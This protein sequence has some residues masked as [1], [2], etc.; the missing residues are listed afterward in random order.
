MRSAQDPKSEPQRWSPAIFRDSSRRRS[1]RVVSA[2]GGFIRNWQYDWRKNRIP[3]KQLASSSPLQYMLLDCVEQALR[4]ARL[5]VACLRSQRTAV[6]VGGGFGGEFGAALVTSIRIPEVERTLRRLLAEL[7][8]PSS[9]QQS[10]PAV[11]GQRLLEAFPGIL[12]ETG[13]FT[14]SALASRISKHY[15]LTGGA[16]AIDSGEASALSALMVARN[17]IEA[18]VSDCVICAVGNRAVDVVDFEAASLSGLLPTDVPSAPFN[19]Q[20]N[21]STLG[22]GAG[23]L[24]LKSLPRAQRDGDAILGVVRGLGV[25]CSARQPSEAVAQAARLACASRREV[26]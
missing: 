19:A 4:E 12:D 24:L 15:D 25:A 10:L 23:V 13:S 21:G 17:L 18:D 26:G 11:F 1:H 7:G 2:S 8:V 9:L 14:S 3:P 16:V 22:E 5:D 6:V 20:V